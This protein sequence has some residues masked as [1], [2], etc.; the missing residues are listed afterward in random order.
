MEHREFEQDVV[1]RLAGIETAIKYLSEEVVGLKDDIE[2]IRS[3]L[4]ERIAENGRQSATLEHHA[5]GLAELREDY[6]ALETKTDSLGKKVWTL[7]G[8][9]I[10]ASVMIPIIIQIIATLVR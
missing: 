5:H 10:T 4:E 9:A 6:T 8:I 2:Y 7:W 1:E 3:Q